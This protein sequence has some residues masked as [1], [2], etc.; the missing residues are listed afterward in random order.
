MGNIHIVIQP[1]LVFSLII[2]TVLSVF[3]IIAGKK[4]MAADPTAR[5]KGIVLVCETGLKMLNDYLSTLMPA[6]FAKNYYPY[7]A[8]IFIYMFLC[9]ISGLFGFNPPTSNFTITLALTAVTF[10]LIQY[11]AL[12]TKGLFT[13]IKDVVWPPT[14]ILG[15]IAP[16]ISLSMRLFGNIIAGSILM[17]L[18]YSFT[19]WLSG[20]IIDF[21]FLGPILAP[22]LHV[23]FDVF[24]GF[25]QTLVFVTLSSILIALE[26]EGE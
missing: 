17:S 26:A 25:I 18:V 15:V 14:N 6:R 22:V 16:L 8:L 10:T 7:F 19:A 1:E 20:M 13:Y 9:N 2:M 21:N 5:P 12:K 11:N 24:A 4:V 23:Y 3:F